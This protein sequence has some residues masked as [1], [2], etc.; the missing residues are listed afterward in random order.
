LR[1]RLSHSPERPDQAEIG[2]V[3]SEQQLPEG[4]RKVSKHVSLDVSVR[5][6]FDVS[7][8]V[9]PMQLHCTGTPHRLGNVL[10]VALAPRVA[11]CK[12]RRRWLEAQAGTHSP[13]A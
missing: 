12:P 6:T 4:I 3:E 7:D 8:G 11:S 9:T 5:L 13:A 10:A 2:K 1:R